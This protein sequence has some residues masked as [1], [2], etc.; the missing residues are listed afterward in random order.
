MDDEYIELN[1]FLK[2]VGVASTGGQ[3][4][5]IIRA[6]EISVNGAIEIRN[7]RKLHVGDVILYDNKKY[8]VEEKMI[9]N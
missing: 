9:K 7:K 6:G 2:I 1:A 5:M 4:K 3:A 8:V